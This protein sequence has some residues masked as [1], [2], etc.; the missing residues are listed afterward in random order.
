[1]GQKLAEYYKRAEKIGG[2]KASLRLSLL[3]CIPLIFARI[4]EDSPENIEIFEKAIKKIEDKYAN[5]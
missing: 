5:E 3:T 1:M 2:N 4:I